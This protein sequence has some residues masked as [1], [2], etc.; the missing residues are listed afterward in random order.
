MKKWKKLL[1]VSLSIFVLL[2]TKGVLHAQTEVSAPSAVLMEASTG[3]VLY[4]KAAQERR[5]PASLTK[6]MTLLLALEAVEE[7]RAQLSDQVIVSEY[8]ASMG[9]SQVYL[10]QGEEQSLET[11]LKCIAVSSGNDASVAVAEYIAGSEAAFVDEM[12]DKAGKLGLFNTHFED[13]CGLTDSDNH[14]TCAMDVAIMSRELINKYPQIYEYTKIWMEPIIHKTSKGQSEFML[15]S[16]NKLLKRYPYATGLKT[17]STSKA[18]YCISATARKD[19]M[20]LIAVIL[21]ADTPALRFSEAQTLLTY[22]FG[23]CK[24]YVDEQPHPLEQASVKG[25][26]AD[27]VPLEYEEVF[28]YVDTEGIDFRQIKKEIVMDMECFKAPVKKGQK[29]GRAEYYYRDKKIGEVSIVF[30]QTLERGKYMEYLQK[31][32][33]IFLL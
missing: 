17:G 19:Q 21:G 33:D 15:S 10:A 1:A 27:K 30:S 11:L 24:L 22:G 2:G 5:S 18:K 29:A 12:N 20:D 23:C 4:D 28:S 16:T 32:L 8:A 26:V 9:G 3:K 14:Y 7:G 31:M 13:C 6:I 25:A